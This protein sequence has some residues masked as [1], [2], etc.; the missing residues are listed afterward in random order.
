MIKS[1]VKQL[2]VSSFTLEANNKKQVYHV[3]DP[4]RQIAI[5]FT[6]NVA[7]QP[8]STQ[9]G[10][11]SPNGQQGVTPPP[12]LIP[13]VTFPP[14]YQIPDKNHHSAIASSTTQD[15]SQMCGEPPKAIVQLIVNG[16]PAG[17]QPW[18]VSLYEG[19]RLNYEYFCA[20]NLITNK[21][22]ITGME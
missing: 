7:W 17:P 6:H 12:T 22:V 18:L 15:V 19:T 4:N 13:P 10:L 21:H 3:L 9:T 20:G 2:Q 14:S 11:Q 8:E 5:G 16:E 1:N